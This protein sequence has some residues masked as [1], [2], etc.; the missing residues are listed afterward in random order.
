MTDRELV[1]YLERRAMLIAS[2]FECTASRRVAE[3]MLAK[4]T[5][6][7]TEREAELAARADLELIARAAREEC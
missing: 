1:A 6:A 4:I 5:E 3:E 7:R 2:L